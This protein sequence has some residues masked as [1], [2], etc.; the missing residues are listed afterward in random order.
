M[1]TELIIGAVGTVAV[2]VI[3]T[4]AVTRIGQDYCDKTIKAGK[5]I[6]N[7]NADGK[8]TFNDRPFFAATNRHD[9]KAYGSLY[10]REKSQLAQ[11]YL[12]KR[13]KL[14]TF[15]GIYNNQIELTKDIKRA[16]VSN[17]RKVLYDKMNAD[18]EFKKAVFDNIK[19]TQYGTNAETL[20][21]NNP[22][23]FYDRFNQALATPAFQENGVHTKFYS[24]LKSK[25]YNAIL[26]INDT[27]YSGY[28]KISKDPTIFF[29]SDSF[30]KISSKKLSDQEIIDNANKYTV[31][32]LTKNMLKKYGS[33]VVGSAAYNQLRN[34]IAV[35]QYLKEHPN[36][37]LSDKEI[38][39]RLQTQL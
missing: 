17:A 22:K 36:S 32:L 16:S 14:D 37:K 3:A 19:N 20:F 10:P 13:G 25:G 6:Q 33:I 5:V 30:Q 27:R 2:A 35:E 1:K 29:S 34:Q 38:L 8:A 31:S 28:K 23:K 9:K 15:E 4:K 39:E 12:A 11:D 7:I 26:D 18:P 24:A 21:K